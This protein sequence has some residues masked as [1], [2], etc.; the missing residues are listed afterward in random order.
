MNNTT[1]FYKM[2][3]ITENTYRI[4]ETGSVNCYLLIGDMENGYSAYIGHEN[5][6]MTKDQ[7]KT[8]YSYV[9]EIIEK[10]RRG[11]LSRSDSPY[12]A[13]SAV[14]EILFNIRNVSRY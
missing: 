4:E 8:I 5:G 2:E 13:K 9:Q 12:P 14:P 7:A 3:E 11:C 10:K 1:S 6:V